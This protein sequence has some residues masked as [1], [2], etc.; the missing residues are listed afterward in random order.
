[1]SKQLNFDNH[2]DS[3][4]LNELGQN[5]QIY[6]PYKEYQQLVDKIKAEC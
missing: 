6:N 5:D 3:M 2:S 1:V 4:R